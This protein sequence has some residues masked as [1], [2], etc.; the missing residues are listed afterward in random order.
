LLVGCA[1]GPGREAPAESV[2]ADAAPEAAAQPNGE[3]GL[4]TPEGAVLG[5]IETRDNKM[6]IH[7]GQHGPRFTVADKSGQVLAAGLTA[8]QLAKSQPQLHKVYKSSM[9]GLPI[10]ARVDHELRSPEPQIGAQPSR[11]R[12]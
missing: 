8:E 1:Q 12:R 4:T 7:S 5:H 6:T 9:A 3:A 2:E 10:D 11:Y